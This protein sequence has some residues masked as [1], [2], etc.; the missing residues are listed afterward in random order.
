[1]GYNLYNVLLLPLRLALP[2]VRTA[3]S[4]WSTSYAVLRR[5]HPS[6]RP[7]PRARLGDWFCYF[8]T[9]MI[10]FNGGDYLGFAGDDQSPFLN[11]PLIAAPSKEER[12]EKS[13]FLI[14]RVDRPL[15]IKRIA[16]R[17]TKK[18]ETTRIFSM[19]GCVFF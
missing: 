2:L 8:T 15:K 3:I 19:L 12:S 6:P 18:D 14:P 1:M 7:A 17:T 9:M 11:L 10:I 13:R 16:M 4:L 5:S